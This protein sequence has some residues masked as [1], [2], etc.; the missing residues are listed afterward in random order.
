[1]KILIMMFIFLILSS[2][3]QAYAKRIVFEK[4]KD[5]ASAERAFDE[6]KKKKL[7]GELDSLAKGN[8]VEIH[9]CNSNGDNVLVAEPI[10]NEYIL[11]AIIELA[12]SRFEK[13]YTEELE[14]SCEDIYKAENKHKKTSSNKRYQISI[15]FI[16]FGK[17]AN[18]DAELKKLKKSSMYK[19]LNAL[20]IKNNFTIHTRPLGK[21][22]SIVAEPILNSELYS[23]AITLIKKRY[24]HPYTFTYDGYT[25]P[26]FSKSEVAKAEALEKKPVKDMSVQ[27]DS[28]VKDVSL[29]NEV[30]AVIDTDNEKISQSKAETKKEDINITESKQKIEV[31]QEIEEAQK[32]NIQVM[33]VNTEKESVQKIDASAPNSGYFSWWYV[34]LATILILLFVLYR[35][36]KPIYD[37]Y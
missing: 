15:A 13:V 14:N 19:Q 30:V 12:Q 10:Q 3:L 4:F 25:K 33:D 2:S 17:K 24:K 34:F 1:M 35:K 7:Y 36:F 23:E 26:N 11:E 28:L 27:E 8:D 9:V 31:I 22:T 21:Y 5:R 32:D 20:A 37:E 6:F 16:T 18:L 29:V